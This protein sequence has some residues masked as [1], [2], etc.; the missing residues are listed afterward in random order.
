MK[1]GKK[2]EYTGLKTFNQEICA[3]NSGATTNKIAQIYIFQYFKPKINI[4]KNL[5]QFDILN[6]TDIFIG[7]KNQTYTLIKQHIMSF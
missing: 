2:I 5:N 1:W 7:G 4:L 6:K 3:S